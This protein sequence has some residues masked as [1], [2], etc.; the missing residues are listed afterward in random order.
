VNVTGTE[1]SLPFLTDFGATAF[2]SVKKP[3]NACRIS[4]KTGLP[5]IVITIAATGINVISL[6][7]K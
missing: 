6:S 1:N 2:A 4:P 5:T 3:G 7:S